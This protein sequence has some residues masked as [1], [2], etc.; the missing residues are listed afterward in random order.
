VY[1]VCLRAQIAA[2]EGIRAG[3][4]GVD[5]DAIARDIIE[6]E[7]YGANF[8]HGLGHG[9]GLEVHEAPTLS[10]AS[11][12]TLVVGNVVTIEPGIYLPGEGGVRIEDDAVVR[13]E[14]V[15]LLTSFPKQLI[16]VS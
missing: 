4:E 1:E 3:M 10:T 12:S 8:G 14:G 2:C 11:E 7:G 16:E 6:G 5:A 9:L 15:E 13:E